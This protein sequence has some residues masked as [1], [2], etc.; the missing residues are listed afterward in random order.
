MYQNKSNLSGFFPPSLKLYGKE[1]HY[2][3]KR[4]PKMAVGTNLRPTVRI[5]KTTKLSTNKFL[6]LIICL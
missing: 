1:K 3:D 2:F 5:I 4:P 6:M